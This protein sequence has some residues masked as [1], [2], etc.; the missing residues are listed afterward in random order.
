MRVILSKT[1]CGNSDFCYKLPI[2]LFQNLNHAENINPCK[3]PAP[4]QEPTA[5]QFVANLLLLRIER[6]LAEIGHLLLLYIGLV[7]KT[8]KY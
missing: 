1:G 7:I 2:Q 5:T 3:R 8:P 6:K 4:I